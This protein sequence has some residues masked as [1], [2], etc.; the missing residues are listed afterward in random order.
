MLCELTVLNRADADGNRKV[1]TTLAFDS[2]EE[3]RA[4]WNRVFKPWCHANGFVA[5]IV[6][7]FGRYRSN[8]P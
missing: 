2:I 4:F 1:V 7:D 8:L 5:Q 6:G 3:A